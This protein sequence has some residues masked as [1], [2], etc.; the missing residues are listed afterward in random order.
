MSDLF[1]SLC[2]GRGDGKYPVVFVPKRRRKLLLGKTRRPGGE[3][4]PA[5]ARQKAG[6]IRDG[7]RMPEHGQRGIAIPPKPPVA[8]GRGFLQGK[9]AIAVARRWGKERNF[10]GEHC[11]ARGY[12]VSIVGFALEPVRPYIREQEEAD[13]SSGQFGMQDQGAP[14]RDA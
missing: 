7:H 5:L 1:P 8:A 2:H 6:Q 11:G 9:S 3:I 12:A 14:R 13:G 10:T 4:F